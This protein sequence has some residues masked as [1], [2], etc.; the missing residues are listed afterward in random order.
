M[1]TASVPTIQESLKKYSE[2]DMEK[3]KIIV[4]LE[5]LTARMTDREIERDLDRLLVPLR[6]IESGQTTVKDVEIKEIV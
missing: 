2:C 4:E 3:R 6:D 1:V 5:V